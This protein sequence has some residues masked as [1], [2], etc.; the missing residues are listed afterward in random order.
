M[1]GEHPCSLF[2][3]NW[4]EKGLVKNQAMA[5]YDEATAILAACI[6]EHGP[7]T[8]E[9]T[10]PRQESQQ[11]LETLMQSAVGTQYQPDVKSLIACIKTIDGLEQRK[12]RLMKQIIGRKLKGKE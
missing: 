3:N 11:N 9:E 1:D 4:A 12:H 7:L 8:E 10:A 2:Y 6:V 5:E